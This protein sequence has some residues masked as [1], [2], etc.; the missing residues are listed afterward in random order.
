MV[1]EPE[2]QFV[3]K[4]LLIACL[5]SALAVT[6]YFWLGAALNPPPPE[7][8]AG[9]VS[10]EPQGEREARAPETAE[11]QEPAPPGEGEDSPPEPEAAAAETPPAESEHIAAETERRIVITSDTYEVTLSNR[12]AVATSWRLRH[13]NDAEGGPLELIPPQSSRDLYPLALEDEDGVPLSELNNA[14]FT[15]SEDGETLQAPVTLTFEYAE[16]SLAARKTLRFKQNGY[17]ASLETEV[18]EQG[19][20]REHMVAWQGGFADL[21]QNNNALYSKA[22]YFD[23]AAGEL[24]RYDA[25][26]AGEGRITERG[27]FLYAGLEDQF[28]SAAFIPSEPAGPLAVQVSSVPLKTGEDAAEELF[29]GLSAGGGEQNRFELYVGPKSVEQLAAV[30]PELRRIVDFGFFSFLAE[31]LFWML[32]W[33]HDNIVANYGWS[34]VLLTFFI[35]MVLFPLKWKS[36]KSMKKMQALQPLVKQINEKYKGLSMRDPKKAQQNEEMMALY[37]KHGVNPMGGCLPLLLQL[38]FFI[39]FYNVLTVAIEI[40]HASW[41]WVSDL[42]APE[43][44][45]VRVLPL[46]MVVTQFWQQSLT[47]QPTAD[48]AQARIMKFMPLFMGFFFY[49]FSSGLVLYWLTSNLIGVAQQ[50]FL[51]RFP[52]EEIEIEQ[53]RKRKKKKK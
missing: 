10:G 26:D 7:P 53:P 40:R 16:G 47:P 4:R 2:E 31:P 23:L 43:Q 3:Q 11:P 1:P 28:F 24:E 37:K 48:P 29:P 32:R 49:S 5:V 39:G 36:T 13:Y 6:A 41:L 12:G 19:R 44:L 15:V 20:P 34:I 22:F 18:A 38:P 17:L 51:N 46:A 30:S 50:Y 27:R 52:A 8:A 45:A 42:S 14:L 21:A 9:T 33:T 25:G 35:N